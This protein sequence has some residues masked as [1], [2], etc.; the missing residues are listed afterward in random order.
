L[1]HLWVFNNQLKALP[2]SVGNLQNLKYLYLWNNT[3]TSLPKS[4]GDMQ[5][6]IDVDVRRNGLTALPSS[7][8]QWSKVKILYLA[9]N[10]LCAKLDIPNNLKGAKGL[11][12]QQCSADCP[13][14]WLGDGGCDDNDYTY[15]YMKVKP[16]P[17]SGCNTAACEYDKGD[18]PR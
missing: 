9:G 5:S 13:A 3:L 8:S 16:K 17:N 1:N 15:F 14:H 7:V 11:C 12:E 6:L 10:P 18:C 2:G 4:V